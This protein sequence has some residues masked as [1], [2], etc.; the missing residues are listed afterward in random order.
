M[1]HNTFGHLFRVTT[2]GES[3]GIALGCVVD[4]CPPGIRFTLAELQSWLD[5]RKPGQS[6]F[7]TQRREDDLVKVL[8]G[9][10]MDA[11]G[12][13]MITTGTP[14]SMM[15]E[16]TDQ[17]SKDY[18]EIAKSY[19]PG[20]ADYTY[21]LKYGIRDYRGGGRS[22]ARET[23]ARVAAGGLARKVVPGLLVRGALVQIGKHKIDR[24]NWDWNE[25]GNNPFFC[26][27]PKMVP[28]WEDYLDG[29]RK[30]GSSIGAV[31]EVIAEGVPAG[32]GAPIYAKLDQ[33]IASNLMSIN[34]VKGVEIG[35]G[36]GAAEI[37]GEENA[38]EMRMGNDGNPIFLSNHAGGILGGISTGQPVIAR[39]AI[40]PTSSILTERQSIDSDGNNVDIR[41]KGR[42]DP[43]VGIRA[44]PIGEAMLACTIADHYLR[45][46]GQTGRLK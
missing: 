19:R 21:D 15:I 9:V 4:G 12:E 23:A 46:R 26:P 2:W 31:V 32:I 34:A 13:T 37:T 27:D 30:A 42:H 22:S 40:K 20:H 35:N 45:D 33:D 39:F 43:C 17:R 1:S 3:H 25:V 16:N 10:M 11:D 8:S 36:F 18:S 24:A 28:V 38:D 29:I 14:V 41:T 7:V 44:V 5:K 6:R